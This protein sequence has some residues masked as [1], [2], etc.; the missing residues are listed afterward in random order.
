VPAEVLAD[1]AARGGAE[2][3]PLIHPGDRPPG[4]RYRPSAALADFVRC[5]DM[6]CRF[7][8]CDRPAQ[9]CDID[10]SI[11]YHAGGLTH[12]SNL[13]CLRRRQLLARHSL[14]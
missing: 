12:A 11:P 8:N 6:T 5:R 4:P 10:H 3:R 9:L 14:L 1:L 13:K 7:P 2:L